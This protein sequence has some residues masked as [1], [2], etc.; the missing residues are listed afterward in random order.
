MVDYLGQPGRYVEHAGLLIHYPLVPPPG[1]VK[2]A[3][4]S[5]ASMGVVDV[6]SCKASQI[7]F[8]DQIALPQAC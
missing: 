6:S 4:L 2:T 8:K 5:T 7:K 3:A 1:G